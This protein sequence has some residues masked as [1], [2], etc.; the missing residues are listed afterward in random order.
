MHK[1][2]LDFIKP[3]QGQFARNEV[4]IYGTTC[5]HVQQIVL[6]LRE[7]LAD[8]NIATADADH[9]DHGEKH[10]INLQQLGNQLVF[11]T[12]LPLN[13]IQRNMACS[14]ADIVLVNGNHFQADTQIVVC[15]KKKETSLRKRADQLSNVLAILLEEGESEIPGYVREVVKNW[16]QCAVF[17]YD[18]A[19]ELTT[20][21]RKNLL[22]APALKALIMA[23]GKS[24]RMGE[25]KS[26]ITHHTLPQHLHLKEI[27]NAIGIDSFISCR[28]EQSAFFKS[29]GHSVI[30]DRMVDCGPL[31][32]LV[33]AYMCDPNCAWLVVACDVPMLDEEV[34]QELVA[35]RNHSMMATAFISPFDGL[36]EPLIAVW[37]P[38]AYQQI[39]QFFAQGYSCPRKVLI[40]S[41]VKLIECRAPHK[42]QNVN[43][44]EELNMLRSIQ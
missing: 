1:K 6:T 30:A 22:Q 8:F 20:L 18:Q 29:E 33:S 5:E 38:K 35:E 31:G 17:N 4:A 37:E 12:A 41:N 44:K 9:H 10:E 42:L 13:S 25:D 14:Q 7:S 11:T 15:N 24:I 2:H 34:I 40:N 3:K 19:E 43:T 26:Q 36:P 27:F 32:G 23:G 39:M 21:I 28:D 16:K